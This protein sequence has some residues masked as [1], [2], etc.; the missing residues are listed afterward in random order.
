MEMT[1]KFNDVYLWRKRINYFP[2]IGCERMLANNEFAAEQI[3]V[4]LTLEVSC[5]DTN[6][7]IHTRMYRRASVH[8]RHTSREHGVIIM[9]YYIHFD[10]THDD[11]LDQLNGFN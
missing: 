11:F 1:S 4:E 3:I 7:H 6:R 9:G 10:V 2:P 5:T 8:T